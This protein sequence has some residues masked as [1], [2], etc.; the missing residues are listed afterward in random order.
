MLNKIVISV[1]AT[2]FSAHAL[3]I[4]CYGKIEE[5]N[6][7]PAY[8]QGHYA[9]KIDSTNGRWVCSIS[10]QDDSLVLLAYSMQK[11]VRTR[12][13]VSATETCANFTTDWLN[14]SFF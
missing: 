8:C 6:S 11:K 4:D 7:S 5:I 10:D 14:N 13:S 2:L 3:S 12:V 1:A 9:Y